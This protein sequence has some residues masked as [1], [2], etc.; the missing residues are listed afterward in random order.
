MQKILVPTDFSD[1]AANALDYAVNLGVKSKAE[2]IILNVFTSMAD[3]LI[4][5]LDTPLFI[6]HNN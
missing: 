4:K 6:A 2:I 5:E 3:I 1:N